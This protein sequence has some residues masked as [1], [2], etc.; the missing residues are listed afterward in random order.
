[1]AKAS[2]L[3]LAIAALAAHGVCD[4]G[5]EVAG[6]HA[7]HADL[8]ASEKIVDRSV[9][10]VEFHAHQARLQIEDHPRRSHEEVAADQHALQNVAPLA[11]QPDE[12]V[13]RATGAGVR[14]DEDIVIGGRV[15][16]LGDKF[17]AADLLVE[18]FFRQMLLCVRN[19]TRRR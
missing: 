16:D 17:V 18:G 12:R 6:R 14:A 10:L 19:L 7:Q 11:L 2:G 8:G 15:V 13:D 1:M 4:R 5:S 3:H 9:D